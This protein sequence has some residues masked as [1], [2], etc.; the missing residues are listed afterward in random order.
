MGRDVGFGVVHSGTKQ[1]CD[2]FE[3]NAG[4]QLERMAR[5]LKCAIWYTHKSLSRFSGS[6]GYSL[7]T[8][9]LFLIQAKSPLTVDFVG[10]WMQLEPLCA[11][12]FSFLQ[13]YVLLVSMPVSPGRL[14][15][16]SACF[17]TS[18]C[19]LPLLLHL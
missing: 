13:P 1:A 9:M 11:S 10:S 5:E 12:S 7:S 2:E 15:W 4:M 17:L 16:L 18:F 6:L 3:S 14:C 8:L 19:K